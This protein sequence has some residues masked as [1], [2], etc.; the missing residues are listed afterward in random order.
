MPKYTQIL[1][2]IAKNL[3]YDHRQKEERS[4]VSMWSLKTG[5]RG[6]AK[7]VWDTC[8][9]RTLQALHIYFQCGGHVEVQQRTNK[10]PWPGSHWGRPYHGWLT[11]RLDTSILFSAISTV[12]LFARICW[13]KMTIR[14]GT[15]IW[16]PHVADYSKNQR[17]GK[18]GTI[19]NAAEV[20]AVSTRPQAECPAANSA[21][22]GIVP[23]THAL[24]FL[25]ST[26]NLII[27]FICS[28]K[29]AK[30]TISWP[31]LTANRH[32]TSANNELPWPRICLMVWAHSFKS[33]CH[34]IRLRWH[35]KNLPAGVGDQHNVQWQ[36][37]VYFA[38][39]LRIWFKVK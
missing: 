18:T 32:N 29:L 8:T 20:A 36:I 7:F 30:L 16:L 12:I 6:L 14:E 9:N 25:V 1:K 19:L 5:W 33:G 27:M 17:V 35:N 3:S 4:L 28:D 2:Y 26:N 38:I 15:K 13:I 34:W 31:E 21:K 37:S 22:L 11:I 10:K 23:I 24:W 39:Y